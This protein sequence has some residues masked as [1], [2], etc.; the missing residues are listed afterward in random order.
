MKEM[1]S[2]YGFHWLFAVRGVLLLLLLV[3]FIVFLNPSVELW[4]RGETTGGFTTFDDIVTDNNV[5]I[6]EQKLSMEDFYKLYPR[7]VD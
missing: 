4:L 2:E 1:T 6:P 5:T 3:V 7:Q